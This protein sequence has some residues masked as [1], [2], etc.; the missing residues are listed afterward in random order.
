MEPRI[1]TSFSFFLSFL[2]SSVL[3]KSNEIDDDIFCV[4]GRHNSTELEN[5]VR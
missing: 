1:V 2:P 5:K 4:D 3:E